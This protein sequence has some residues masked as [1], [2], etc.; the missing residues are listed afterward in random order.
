MRKIEIQPQNYGAHYFLP[1]HPVVK[2]SSTTTRVHPVFNA[3]AR[4]SAGH[5]LNEHN[6][7]GSQDSKS[8]SAHN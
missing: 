1:H 6:T 3:S 4:N 5:S 7:I 2:D 8:L